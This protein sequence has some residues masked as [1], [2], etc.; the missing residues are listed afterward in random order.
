[1]PSSSFSSRIS[2][3]SGVS[4][5]SS[6]PPGNSQSPPCSLCAGRC[7]RRTRPS[8]SIKTAATTVTTVAAGSAGTSAPVIGIDGDVIMGEIGGPNRRAPRAAGSGVDAY[9]DLAAL[10]IFGAG[11][12]LIIGVA[13][14][15]ARD[16]YIAE[17][18]RKMVA[19][20]RLAG[21]ADRGDDPAPI[22]IL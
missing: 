11:R 21:L 20:R 18:D 15:L 17:P 2:A 12:F 14:P 13:H 1:M 10:D 22:G 4:P 5:A 8:A 7:A 9:F 19:V 16:L 3:A 6:L